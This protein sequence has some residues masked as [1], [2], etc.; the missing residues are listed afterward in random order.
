MGG[1]EGSGV[2]RGKEAVGREG[3]NAEARRT[4]RG[5]RE[6]NLPRNTPNTR[7]RREIWNLTFEI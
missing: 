6:S 4:G 7:K 2:T 1:I 3:I 5:G